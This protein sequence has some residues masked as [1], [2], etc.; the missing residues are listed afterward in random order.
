M[1][2]ETTNTCS[3]MQ[4]LDV[5]CA[6]E[7]TDRLSSMSLLMGVWS[8]SGAADAGATV[9]RP[10]AEVAARLSPLPN[11]SC[12]PDPQPASPRTGR[13]PRGTEPSRLSD[14]ACHCSEL[15]GP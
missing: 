9:T 5:D 2:R 11:Y 10:S 1:R 12:A 14:S 7:T 13:L 3:E 4:T 6:V 8:S 15:M